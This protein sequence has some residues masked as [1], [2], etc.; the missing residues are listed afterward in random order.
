MA[1]NKRGTNQHTGFIKRIRNA[2]LD[3]MVDNIICPIL[4]FVMRK[5]VYPIWNFIKFVTWWGIRIGIAVIM[6]VIVAEGYRYETTPVPTAHADT[7]QI[8]IKEIVDISP[9]LQHIADC[10]SGTRNKKGQAYKDTATQFDKDGTVLERG[11]GD[12]TI[13]T[14]WAQNNS[15]HK[16]EAK[17]MGLDLRD[18]KD[19]QKFAKYLLKT[20]G[21]IP[22]N[23][24]KSCWSQP[25]AN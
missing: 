6:V 16:K 8:E 7:D 17:K 3:F 2:V 4:R 1:N 24:S 19:N 5:I 15:I 21:T 22:W 10:E 23:S 25:Y 9:T 18:E 11:N 13:D 20:Q 12:R 14:G